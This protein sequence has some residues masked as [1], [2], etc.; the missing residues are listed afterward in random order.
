[1]GKLTDRQIENMVEPGR[2][3]DGYGLFYEITKTGNKRFLYRYKIEGRGGMFVIGRYPDI[4]LQKARECHHDARKLVRK[5]LNP[6]EI[7]RTKKREGMA[8]IEGMDP[9]F[10]DP[11]VYS[12]LRW[13]CGR[14]K[15]EKQEAVEKAIVTMAR[16]LGCKF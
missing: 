8:K 7:K 5:G 16:S 12:Y 6:A 13:I 9:V 10:I 3:S 11:G 15:I 2:L 4:S 1:V 14:E